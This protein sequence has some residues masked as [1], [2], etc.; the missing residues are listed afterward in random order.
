MVMFGRPS[1]GDEAAVM[2][3][4]HQGGLACHPVDGRLPE[5]MICF[6]RTQ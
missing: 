4:V 5:T 1:G 6:S 2:Q 3:V